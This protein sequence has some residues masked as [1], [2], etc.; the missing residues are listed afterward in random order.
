MKQLAVITA[1]ALFAAFP[2]NASEPTASAT[3][4]QII[5]LVAA[6]Q[7]QNATM[8]QNQAA[9]EAKLASVSDAVR[10]A[11]TFTSVPRR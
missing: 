8:A 3:D 2:T 9:I 10:Q 6:L 5:A 1:I 11:R 4:Q 7:A